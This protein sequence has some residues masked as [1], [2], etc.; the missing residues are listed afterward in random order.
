MEPSNAT[1]TIII[2]ANTLDSLKF[3]LT[4]VASL[5]DKITTDIGNSDLSAD[6]KTITGGLLEAI[7]GLGAI[8]GKLLPNKQT[9]LVLIGHSTQT[10]PLTTLHRPSTLPRRGPGGITPL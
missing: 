5:C 1:Y 3:D 2:D 4:K 10:L 8:Q 7:M 9:R 6:T